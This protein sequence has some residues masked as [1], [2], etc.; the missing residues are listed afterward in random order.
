MIFITGWNEWVA[1]R[2]PVSLENEPIFFVDCANQNC[3]RD[4]EPMKDGHGDQ[5][6]YADDGLYPSV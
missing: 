4:A 1:Q 6:L 3:S 2:Q 5:L